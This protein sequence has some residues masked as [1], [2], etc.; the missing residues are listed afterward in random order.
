MKFTTWPDLRNIE[1]ILSSKST[2]L[3]VIYIINL[4]LILI[5]G[6]KKNLS[7]YIII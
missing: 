6:F 3:L 2:I 5:F 7:C 1:I 4:M